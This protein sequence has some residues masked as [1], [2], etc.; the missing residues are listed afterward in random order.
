[1]RYQTHSNDEARGCLANDLMVTADDDYVISRSIRDIYVYSSATRSY[2][3]R[4]LCVPVRAVC[5]LRA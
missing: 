3:V 5:Q 2:R 4:D 1:M